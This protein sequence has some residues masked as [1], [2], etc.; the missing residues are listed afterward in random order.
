MCGDQEARVRFWY[1]PV[2]NYPDTAINNN[3]NDRR[4]I[5]DLAV[6]FIAKNKIS[7]IIV[8]DNNL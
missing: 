7:A 3:E 4:E 6:M 1:W 8:A 2:I 5:C